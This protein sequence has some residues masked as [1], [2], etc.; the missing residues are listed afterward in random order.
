MSEE[1]K[2]PSAAEIAAELAAL[3]KASAPPE[4][5]PKMT[6]QELAEYLQVYEPD[7]SFADAF[8][9]AIIDEEATAEDRLAALKG[10]RDGIVNQ[11]NRAAELMLEEKLNELEKK[12]APATSYAQQAQAEQLWNDFA[13]EHPELKDQSEMVDMVATSLM[14]GGFK[15]KNK[16]EL[17][18]KVAEGVTGILQKTNPS[19]KA[20]SPKSPSSMPSM[21]GSN[22][23]PGGGATTKVATVDET[24]DVFD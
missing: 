18:D 9:T 23:T 16:K 8:R 3:Q 13:Q 2:Q 11:A 17:F 22:G 19:F 10:M 15:P 24:M 21:A 7:A 14:S 5:P 6:E 1:T 4:Q 12:F 20:A